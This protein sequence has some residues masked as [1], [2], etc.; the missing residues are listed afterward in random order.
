MK[1]KN[2]LLVQCPNLGPSDFYVSMWEIN[3]SR[4]ISMCLIMFKYFN[5]EVFIQFRSQEL[6]MNAKIWI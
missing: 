3:Y 6:F 2:K 1:E 4:V 5:I